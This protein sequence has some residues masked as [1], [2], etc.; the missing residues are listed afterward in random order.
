LDIEW[1]EDQ[2]ECHTVYMTE[3]AL[4]GAALNPLDP[5]Y[6]SLVTQKGIMEIDSVNFMR[7]KAPG[8]Y[9][10]EVLGKSPL[11]T[12]KYSLSFESLQRSLQ[13]RGKMKRLVS[14]ACEQDSGE[15]LFRPLSNAFCVE[16]HPS[17]NYYLAGFE[18][19]EKE[20]LIHLY[21]YGQ[22]RDLI[23][24]CAG[25]GRISQCHFDTY[26]TNFAGCDAKGSLKL[27]KFDSSPSSIQP[28]TS[29]PTSLCYDACFLD[30]TSLV[31]SGGLSMSFQ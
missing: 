13:H 7:K 20:G 8:S 16:P 28:W 12:P 27:W 2:L 3:D 10:E 22:D 31:A 1:V 24:Y 6:M 4:G 14:L 5:Q 25:N 15:K 19:S 30:S 21:Q 26:G 18:D 29:L 9:K 17:F 23:T 11:T